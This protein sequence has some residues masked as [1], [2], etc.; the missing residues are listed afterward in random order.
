MCEHRIMAITSAFRA[1]DADSIPTAR[2]SGHELYDLR[3]LSF[4]VGSENSLIHPHF[5]TSTSHRLSTVFYSIE[6]ARCLLLVKEAGCVA[7]RLRQI[8]HHLNA[9][10]L[11]T[12]I[13]INMSVV[14]RETTT[15]SARCS[16]TLNLAT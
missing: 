11:I 4:F 14:Y 2:S 8:T 9:V 5:V 15:Y 6:M 7:R 12:E 10:N 1:D 16:G 3:V 13:F